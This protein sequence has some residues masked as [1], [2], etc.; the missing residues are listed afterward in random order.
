MRQFRLTNAAGGTFDL[1]R[2]DAFFHAPSGLGLV[3]ETDVARVGEE[4]LLLDCT[5]GQK[6]VSGEMVFAGYAQYQE[7]LAFCVGELELGYQPEG[8]LWYY[9]RCILQRID[10]GEIDTASRRLICP[11]DLL[12]TTSWYAARRTFSTGGAVESPKRYAYTY[13]YQYSDSAQGTAVLYN[14]GTLPAPCRIRIDGP[15]QNPSWA[16]LAAGEVTQRGKV[17]AVIPAGHRLEVDSSPA[18]LTIEEVTAAG[19]P[20]Q[21]LYQQSDFS[22]G[23][24][25]TLPV[26]ESRMTFAHDGSDPIHAEIEVRELAASV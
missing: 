8:S 13:P 6:T 7:F 4:F 5:L 11:V 1:M 20:V 2:K 25:I 18:S 14:N 15:C 12:L 21:S 26:G 24:F 22:T 17:L 19:E 16:L 9:A 3:Y 10:K 23:R